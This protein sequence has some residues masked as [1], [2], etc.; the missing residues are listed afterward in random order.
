MTTNRVDKKAHIILKTLFFTLRGRNRFGKED[1]LTLQ[2]KK[3]SPG[4]ILH[5]LE[6]THT[7]LYTYWR[8]EVEVIVQSTEYGL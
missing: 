1:D 7:H 2:M 6:H 4:C 3:V 8:I 5:L